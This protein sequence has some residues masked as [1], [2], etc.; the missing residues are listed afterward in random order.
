VP[1]RGQPVRAKADPGPAHYAID[2]RRELP[3]GPPPHGWQHLLD[4]PGIARG[5]PYVPGNLGHRRTPHWVGGLAAELTVQL[6]GDAR[7]AALRIGLERHIDEPVAVHAG[8]VEVGERG[9]GRDGGV[10]GP[11]TL[12][13]GGA[14]LGQAVRVVELGAHRIVDYCVE[15]GQRSCHGTG[16]LD[17]RVDVPRRNAHVCVVR[18]AGDFHVAAP[19]DREPR[20]GDRG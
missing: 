19:V 9:L 13:A 12:L 16:V 20:A 7:D 8:G 14:V 4:A 3:V 18:R 6:R 2:Q 15:F 11:A 10:A 1:A 17:I 5:P